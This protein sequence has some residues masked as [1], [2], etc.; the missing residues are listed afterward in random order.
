M[1]SCGWSTV[2]LHDKPVIS[3][4]RFSQE[5]KPRPQKLAN[6]IDRLTRALRLT[7]SQLFTADSFSAHGI[8]KNEKLDTNTQKHTR[9]I[10]DQTPR[11]STNNFVVI[12][13]TFIEKN[14]ILLHFIMFRIL[15]IEVQFTRRHL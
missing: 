6:I 11:S 10:R 15:S 7:V 12:S 5:T 1:P 4:P 2:C 8:S 14:S 3:D 13:F 9:L